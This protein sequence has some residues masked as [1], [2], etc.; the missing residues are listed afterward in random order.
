MIR[1]EVFKEEEDCGQKRIGSRGV[2]TQKEKV[3]G[4]I[5][6]VKGQLLAQGFQE[7]EKPK[8]DYL[9]MLRELLKLYFALPQIK[10]SRLEVWI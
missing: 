6:Q 10:D 2:V 1:Y 7:D 4:W 5:A 3:D 9:T 8:P